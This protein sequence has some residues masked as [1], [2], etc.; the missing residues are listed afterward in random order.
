M[1]INNDS[2]FVI[3]NKLGVKRILTNKNY[4]GIFYFNYATTKMLK[5]RFINQPSFGLAYN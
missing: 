4:N 2:V 1:H 3:I 5:K